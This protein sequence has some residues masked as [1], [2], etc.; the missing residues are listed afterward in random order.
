MGIK[1]VAIGTEL[2]VLTK[3]MTQAKGWKDYVDQND[4]VDTYLAG[5]ELDKFVVDF[6]SQ[7]VKLVQDLGLVEKK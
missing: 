3:K 6:N 5:P 4:Q 2:P 7:L 1:D